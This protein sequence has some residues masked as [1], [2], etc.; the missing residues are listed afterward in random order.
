M[1]RPTLWSKIYSPIGRLN[2][3]GNKI[4]SLV[5]VFCVG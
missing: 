5:N 3:A 2:E 4:G 1:G